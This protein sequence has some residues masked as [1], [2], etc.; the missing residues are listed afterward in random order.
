MFD[1]LYGCNATFPGA[2]EALRELFEGCSNQIAS[3]Q[4]S[5]YLLAALIAQGWRATPRVS[6][7]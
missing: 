1:A 7:G 6:S 3:S 4:E 5:D 2:E